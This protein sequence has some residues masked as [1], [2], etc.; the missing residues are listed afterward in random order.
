M[1]DNLKVFELNGTWSVRFNNT[2]IVA[3]AGPDA[4]ERAERQRTELTELLS[5]TR[6]AALTKR[7]EGLDRDDT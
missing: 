5:Q 4:R 3:F 6:S 1:D 7:T 2:E